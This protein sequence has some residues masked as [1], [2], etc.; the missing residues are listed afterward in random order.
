MNCSQDSG[1]AYYTADFLYIPD[2]NSTC[3][4][5]KSYPSYSTCLIDGNNKPAENGE[6]PAV[7]VSPLEAE[8]QFMD[9]ENGGGK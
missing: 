4:Y 1:N 2:A 8:L 3:M 7:K 5:T 6:N 9:D